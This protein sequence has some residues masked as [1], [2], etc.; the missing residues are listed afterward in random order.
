[1]VNTYFVLLV[2]LF[3]NFLKLLP[4]SRRRDNM[5]TIRAKEMSFDPECHCED[6]HDTG[7]TGD[8]CPGIAGNREYVLCDCNTQARLIRIALRRKNKCQQE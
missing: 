3:I 5:K 6:C 2:G 7:W 8:I 1:M 4:G